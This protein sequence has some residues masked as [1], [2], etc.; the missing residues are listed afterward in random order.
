MAPGGVTYAFQESCS[1]LRSYTV[2]RVHRSSGQ[3][4]SQ[5][6]HY[7]K[8]HDTD[9]SGRRRA[10]ATVAAFHEE[11]LVVSRRRAIAAAAAFR[12]SVIGQA[13]ERVFQFGILDAL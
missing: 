7:N 13:R 11:C 6:G 2:A 3:F 10:V 4:I 5:S 9:A 8:Q 1:A 12:S